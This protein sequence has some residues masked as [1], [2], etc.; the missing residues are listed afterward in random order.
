MVIRGPGAQPSKKAQDI[1]TNLCVMMGHVYC[2]RGQD[3]SASK[4]NDF[5]LRVR[6]DQL[7][8]MHSEVANALSNSALSMVGYGKDLNV[9]LK[10]LERSLEIDLANPREDHKKVPPLR[11]FNTE[12]ALRALGRMAEARHHVDEAS[13]CAR[14]E[15]WKDSRYLTM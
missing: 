15:F 2:E 11:H 8:P 13:A 4:Y 10:M 12:F 3:I 1:I 6:E 9:A 5:V 7:G 14:A